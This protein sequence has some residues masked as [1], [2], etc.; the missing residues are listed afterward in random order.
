MLKF[1]KSIHSSIEKQEKEYSWYKYLIIFWMIWSSY[2]IYLLV[3]NPSSISILIIILAIYSG[4]LYYPMYI[5]YTNIA[6]A[7]INKK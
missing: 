3:V 5:K 7:W 2:V 6:I 1:L 4:V